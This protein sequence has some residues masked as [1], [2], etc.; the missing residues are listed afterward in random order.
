MCKSEIVTTVDVTCSS[1]FLKLSAFDHSDAY[2]YTELSPMRQMQL[3]GGLRFE[4]DYVTGGEHAQQFLTFY[5]LDFNG[6][7]NYVIIYVEAGFE[8]SAEKDSYLESILQMRSLVTG[9]Y[10]EHDISFNVT[11]DQYQ[12][13]RNDKNAT[14]FV[15]GKLNATQDEL[16]TELIDPDKYTCPDVGITP[17]NKL[18]TCPYVNVDVNQFSVRINGGFLTFYVYDI[19]VASFSRWEY[20]MQGDIISLCFED[21][22]VIY[23]AMHEDETSGGTSE[24]SKTYERL[25]AFILTVITAIKLGSK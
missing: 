16:T 14:V 10:G 1:F 4:L 2:P 9:Y 17:L 6:Y 23:E 24:M 3:T 22:M 20:D 7:I 18:Y 8:D 19:P 13:N 21:F 12:M 15:P 25:F 11:V 5:K